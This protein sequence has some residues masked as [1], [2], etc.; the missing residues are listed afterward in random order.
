MRL[1][2]CHAQTTELSPPTLLSVLRAAWDTEEFSVILLKPSSGN[3]LPQG[4][5]VVCVL[6]RRA[7]SELGFYCREWTLDQSNS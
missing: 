3:V 7:L 2:L 1:P 5:M 4:T 6:G